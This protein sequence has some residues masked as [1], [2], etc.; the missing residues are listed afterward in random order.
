LPHG[1]PEKTGRYR[2]FIISAG[3]S[4]LGLGL[5]TSRSTTD[6]VLD[7]AALALDTESDNR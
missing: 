3:A 6:L 2:D 7:D 4:G 1:A 5:S